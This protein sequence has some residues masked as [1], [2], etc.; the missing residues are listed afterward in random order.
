MSN[1]IK[2]STSQ[3][4][5]EKDISDIFCSR[6]EKNT[7]LM[8]KLYKDLQKTMGFFPELLY[9]ELNGRVV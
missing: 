3:N 5:G 6:S 7:K 2:C 8:Q 4:V 1:E 9:L